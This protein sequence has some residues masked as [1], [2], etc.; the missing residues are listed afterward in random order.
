MDKRIIHGQLMNEHRII[1]NEIADIKA[2]SFE[3]SKEQKQRISELEMKLKVIAQKLYTLYLQFMDGSLK[4]FENQWVVKS[5]SDTD[6]K[7]YPIWEENHEWINKSST[8]KFIKDGIE[9]VYDII[10]TGEYSE[11]KQQIV[12]T[13]FAKIKAIYFE[14]L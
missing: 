5:S 13:D 11:E 9:V 6:N 4:F 10:T 14:S 12:K 7:L 2:S 1:S 3:L 8:K